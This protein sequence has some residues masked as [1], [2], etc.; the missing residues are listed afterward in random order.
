APLVAE[1]D[2]I[3]CRVSLFVD[4]GTT[5]GLQQARAIGVAR[6]ELYTGPYARAFAEGDANAALARCVS[7][8]RHAAKAG[9]AVNAGHDLDQQNLGAFRRAIPQL[10]EV[11]IGHALIS[12]ALYDGL[13]TTVRRYLS[14]L[15]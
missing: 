8:A 10:A 15:V 2:A 3:G 1:L 9:L 5:T 6:V 11:S 4:A 14:I 7:T 13:A 12:E